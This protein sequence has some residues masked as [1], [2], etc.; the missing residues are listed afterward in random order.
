MNMQNRCPQCLFGGQKR[1]P[2]LARFDGL[3]LVGL[4][5]A[6]VLDYYIFRLHRT[7]AN[8]G[9]GVMVAWAA[10]W[11]AKFAYDYS[12]V[13][14]ISDFNNM[15]ITQGHRIGDFAHYSPERPLAPGDPR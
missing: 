2:S 12:K 1:P 3:N 13:N 8:A 4:A 6:T 14:T 5:G 7:D 10:F 11:Q 9:V 15:G